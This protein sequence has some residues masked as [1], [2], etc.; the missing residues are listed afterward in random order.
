MI[1]SAEMTSLVYL[2]AKSVKSEYLQC[3]YFK[4]RKFWLAN[5]I[6]C[7]FD[8]SSRVFPNNSTQN[9]RSKIQQ[10]VKYAA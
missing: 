7:K 2:R 6:I 4:K 1:Q 9:Y 10:N 5:L 3:F 8:F